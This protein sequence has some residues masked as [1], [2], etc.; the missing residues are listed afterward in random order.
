MSSD[1]RSEARSR[2]GKYSSV[3]FSTNKEALTY[4]FKIR[5]IASSGI[6]IL[7]NEG[8]AVLK[9]LK[10]GD[11]LNMKY[12]PLNLADQPEYIDTE[13]K[14][15]TKDEKGRFKGHYLVGLLVLEKQKGD[16]E[17][18]HLDTLIHSKKIDGKII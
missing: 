13:I 18:H 3:E 6:G 1:K 7:V 15:I 10:V 12:Y 16:P 5:D 2:A 17:R 11:V 14:H 8:S 9:S 4:Q